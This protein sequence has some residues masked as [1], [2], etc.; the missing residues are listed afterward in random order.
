MSLEGLVAKAESCL[1]LRTEVPG[2]PDWDGEVIDAGVSFELIQNTVDYLACK[3]QIEIPLLD[4]EKEFM[5]ALFE[6]MWGGGDYPAYREAAALANH[7]V[8]G[9]GE[10]LKINDEVC[11]S[12]IIVK[13]VMAAL[14]VWIKALADEKKPYTLTGSS[15]LLFLNSSHARD[16]MEGRRHKAAQGVMLKSGE[17]VVENDNHRL[18]SVTQQFCLHVKTTRSG[19]GP[20]MSTW[21][22]EGSY[23]FEPFSENNHNTSIFFKR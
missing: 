8:N 9:Q 11:K 16:L 17:L 10:Q 1:E 22:M 13:G 14:Q 5:K 12:A 7:Y 18:R 15:D 4:D 19:E 3:A 20:F 21:K 2:A 6:D 23:G